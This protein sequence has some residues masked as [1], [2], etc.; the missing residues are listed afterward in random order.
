M[1]KRRDRPMVG[2]ERQT[3]AVHLK[4]RRVIGVAKVGR[5]SRNISEHPL[6]VRRQA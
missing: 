1:S 3:I 2:D 4:D 5:A 6:Q